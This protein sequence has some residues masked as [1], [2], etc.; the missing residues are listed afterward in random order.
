MRQERPTAAAEPGPSRVQR[1]VVPD[2]DETADKHEATDMDSQT[3]PDLFDLAT[4]PDI[5]EELANEALADGKT[6]D[7]VGHQL[8][9][10]H[11][12][13]FGGEPLEPDHIAEAVEEIVVEDTT[14]AQQDLQDLAEH[15]QVSVATKSVLEGASQ[16]PAYLVSTVFADK[17]CCM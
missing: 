2:V 4:R 14:L 8:D 1:R 7:E 9:Q 13:G 10:E 11:D 16:L 6:H 3:A 12:L 5:L 15:V 17:T